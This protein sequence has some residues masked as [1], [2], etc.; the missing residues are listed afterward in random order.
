[1]AGGSAAAK[2]RELREK[3]ARL[4]EQ[5]RQ[6]DK[7]AEGERRTAAVLSG[8]AA[9][10]Y[11]VLDDL[12]IPGSKANI[13]H[14]VIGP[15]GVTVIETKAYTGRVTLN[16]GTLWHGKYP[17]RRELAAATFE[18]DKVREI[19]A[20]TG[21]DVLVRSVMC[22]HGV[23]VPRDP[24]RRLAP[25]ELCGP[26]D[27]LTT[28]DAA[29]ARLSPAHVAHLA[30]LIEQ[31]LPPQRLPARAAP[32][33]P[34]STRQSSQRRPR[35]EVIGGTR[36]LRGLPLR[37]RRPAKEGVRRGALLVLQLL[38]VVIGGLLM[39]AVASVALQSIAESA[40]TSLTTSTTT[41]V[42]PSPPPE[43]ETPVPAP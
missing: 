28:I 36:R 32:A 29:P 35:L 17:L 8:L 13:D 10:G 22:L 26:L 42:A 20:S 37:A 16:D 3:A 38:V 27:L 30:T 33:E 1:M 34:P 5:A 39:I 7:G 24:D 2:A 11:V 18:A 19:V 21:W 41:T 23:D 14:V 12:S 43:A 25:I 6:W 31:A 9:R 15:T 40:K 4:E